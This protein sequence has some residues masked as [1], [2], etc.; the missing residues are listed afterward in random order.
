MAEQLANVDRTTALFERPAMGVQD[1]TAFAAVKQAIAEHF[2]AQNVEEF[3]RSLESCKLRIRDFELVLENG[4][5]GGD[6]AA[7]YG[8]LS[9]GDQG[10]IREFYLASLEQVD[11]PLRDRYFKLYAYY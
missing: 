8:K 11:V 4:K 6:T 3:L 2:A 10:Q 5:L 9:D 1:A 7:E